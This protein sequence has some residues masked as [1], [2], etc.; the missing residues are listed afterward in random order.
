MK[1]YNRIKEVLNQ[2]GKT[3]RWLSKEIEVSETTVSRWAHNWQQ[4]SIETLYKIASAVNLEAR[5]LIVLAK[6][7]KEME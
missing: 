3:N 6:D 2:I 5:E 4:P 1:N 7:L